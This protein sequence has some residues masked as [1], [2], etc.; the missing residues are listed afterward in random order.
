MFFRRNEGQYRETDR[1]TRFKLVKSGKH[2]LRAAT[3]HFGLFKIISGRVD[4]SS[5]SVHQVEKEVPLITSDRFLKGV[6]ATGALLGG[7]VATYAVQA[8]EATSPSAVEHTVSSTTDVLA[9]SDS[10]VLGHSSESSQS[11][12]EA[13]SASISESASVEASVSH[14]LSVSTSASESASTSASESASTSA[15]ESAST[16]ASQSASTSAS[17][18]MSSS[19]SMSSE[20]VDSQVV[21]G[22]K[23]NS[24]VD[25]EVQV[26]DSHMFSSLVDLNS[27]TTNITSTATATIA[28]TSTSEV[29]SKKIDED[30][31]K[32]AKLSAE[33]GE[34]LAKIADLPNTDSVVLKVGDA[35]EKIESSLKDP[36]SD[37]RSVIEEA[38]LARDSIADAVLNANSAQLNNPNSQANTQSED[39]RSTDSQ[40]QS[41]LN[42]EKEILDQN[43]SEAEILNKL[44]KNYATTVNDPNQKAT[45]D[46]AIANV[47][48]EIAASTDLLATNASLQAYTEQRKRLGDSIDQLMASMN[49]AGF[50]GNTTVNG[51]PAI[52]ANLN[53]A[54]G[55]TKTYIGTG[56]DPNYNI[57]IYYKLTVTND[58]SNLTFVYTITYDNPAT[59]TV[60]IPSVLPNGYSIYN[61]GT[62]FQTMFTLGKG[63]GTPQV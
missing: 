10:A 9:A 19:F 31:K 63:L 38:T 32:L 36:T 37:L 60:E 7:G 33:M 45:I 25:S 51:A 59:S 30:R 6:A 22:E 12:T 43:L 58:G 1:V 53:I 26:V 40:N 16:S 47:E 62:Y 34:Y 15:S 49:A 13:T 57:P 46:Q 24:T 20:P 23:L 29:T 5:V 42:S 39:T 35:L 52:S 14:S 56:T 41:K 18:S 27:R 55:E 21:S 8:D 2:W 44:A 17:E 4:A 61:T 54:K 28:M 50:A 11:Q 48:K 3:S